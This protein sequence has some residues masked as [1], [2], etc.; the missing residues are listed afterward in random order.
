MWIAF[1]TGF[2]VVIVINRLKKHN[3]RKEV[4]KQYQTDELITAILP[5]IDKDS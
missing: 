4:K 2:I 1:I 5:T 3:K